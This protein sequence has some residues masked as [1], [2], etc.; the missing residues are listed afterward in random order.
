MTTQG[1]AMV[2]PATSPL[3][4]SIREPHPSETELS[5]GSSAQD[6]Q[7]FPNVINVPVLID[8]QK[9]ED[10]YLIYSQQFNRFSA[11]KTIDEARGEIIVD[12]L[13]YFQW[14]HEE[15]YG[16]TITKSSVTFKEWK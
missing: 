13:E 8:I 16:E 5:A 3:T 1:D 15:K 14:L 7:H 2:A 11:G 6:S 4:E 12:L 9:T 10:G